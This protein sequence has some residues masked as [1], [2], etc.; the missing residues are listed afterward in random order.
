MWGADLS[1]SEE[2]IS[3]GKAHTEIFGELVELMKNHLQPR[4]S[5]IV[6]RFTFHSRNRKEGETVA[7]YVAELKKFSEHCGFGD[8]LN[9]MLRD[10]LVCGINDGGIQRRLL[11]EPELTYKKALDL[12][13][14][15]EAA[16][17]NVLDLKG[18]KVDTEKLYLV[19][20]TVSK[21]QGISCYRC[22]GN[23]RAAECHFKDLICHSCG[24]QGHIARVAE[25]R[26]SG[27]NHH[28]HSVRRKH[29]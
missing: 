15:M 18:S 9:D 12:A 24:K 26:L 17:R 8:T 5:V 22:G 23:H 7:V 6:E 25:A 11:S 3:A 29:T 14:A 2:F 19:K 1:A 21:N 27:R 4:P 16:E 20:D 28:F 13:Q 10:R